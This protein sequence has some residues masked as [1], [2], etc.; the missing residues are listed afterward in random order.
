V[1]KL[2]YSKMNKHTIRDKRIARGELFTYPFTV[3]FYYTNICFRKIIYL[4]LVIFLNN[5]YSWWIDFFLHIYY[6]TF[7]FI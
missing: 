5:R 3:F 6:P 2:K 1:T 4:F 7:I